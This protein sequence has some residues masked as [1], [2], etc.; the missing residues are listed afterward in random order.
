[1]E[2]NFSCFRE[3]VIRSIAL[4]IKPFKLKK[5]KQLISIYNSL[6]NDV[7]SNMVPNETKHDA[8]YVD[9]MLAV[10]KYALDVSYLI[11]H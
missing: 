6:Q 1:M 8:Q 3:H 2:K 9:H 5:N 11:N 10:R 4:Q 7:S